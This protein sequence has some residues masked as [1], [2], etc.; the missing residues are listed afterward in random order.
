M[1]SCGGVEECIEEWGMRFGEL[2]A[3][4]CVLIHYMGREKRLPLAYIP[5]AFHY[6]MCM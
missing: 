1:D 6:E 3:K 4:D 2:E 5:G